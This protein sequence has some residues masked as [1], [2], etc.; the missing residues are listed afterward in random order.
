M[1]VSLHAGLILVMPQTADIAAYEQ[2]LLATERLLR[3]VGEQHWA[4]WLQEDLAAWRGSGDVSHHRR[5][6]GGMGSFNDVIICRMNQHQVSAEQEP[7][8]NSLFEWLKAILYHFSRHPTE[9]PSAEALRKAVGR[10]A[11]SLSA[12]VG[13]EHAPD[14]MRGF[15]GGP[16]KVS[17]ARC[18]TCGYAEMTPRDIDSAIA[19]ELVPELVFQACVQ[20]TLTDIVD[21][22]LR[23]DVPG[24]AERRKQ[25]RAAVSA[26]GIGLTERDGWMRPCPNCKADDSAVYRWSYVNGKPPTF[27]PTSDNLALRTSAR[28][29]RLRHNPPMQR[30]GAAGILSGIRKWFGRGPGR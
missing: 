1:I 2:A 28:A 15:A 21:Q 9:R 30:T 13:G 29:E 22:V 23:L 16:V 14:S 3:Q 17:G 12:F 26:S 19:D 25:L 24:L 18:L 7:W 6:Y 11:P 10:H 27:Q 4:K 20:G 5:A 8:A